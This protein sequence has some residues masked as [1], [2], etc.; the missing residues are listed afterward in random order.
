MPAIESSACY[1]DALL[2]PGGLKSLSAQ[3]IGFMNSVVPD[4]HHE[5][6]SLKYKPVNKKFVMRTQELIVNNEHQEPGPPVGPHQLAADGLPIPRRVLCDPVCI[7]LEWTTP[8]KAGCGLVNQGNTCFLNSV[9]QCLSYTPPLVHYFESGGHDETGCGVAGFCAMCVLSRHVHNVFTKNCAALKPQPVTKNLTKIAKHMR[10]GRQEDAHEFLRYFV[11]ALQKSCVIPF[12]GKLDN[13]TKETT[14]VHQVF[15]GY[16]RS[17]VKCLQCHHESNTYDPILDVSLDIKL[18]NSLTQSFEQYVK[19][20]LLDGANMYKCEQCKCMVKARKSLSIHR[21]PNVLTIQ[22]KRFD[23]SSMFGGKINK[24]VTYGCELNLR[25]YM[26]AKKGDAMMYDLYAVLVHAG[27]SVHSGHYFCFTRTSTGDCYCF[28]DS[29]VRR[30]NLTQLLS[31]QAY[32]LFYRRRVG[33]NTPVQPNSRSEKCLPQHRQQQPVASQ[34]KSEPMIGPRLPTP[35][36]PKPVDPVAESVFGPFA[37]PKQVKQRPKMAAESASKGSKHAHQSSEAKASASVGSNANVPPSGGKVQDGCTKPLFKPIKGLSTNPKAAS[38]VFSQPPRSIG[39]VTSNSNT[40]SS[41]SSSSSSSSTSYQPFNQVSPSKSDDQQSQASNISTAGLRHAKPCAIISPRQ[42]VKSPSPVFTS[43]EKDM[44]SPKKASP[45]SPVGKVA[46]SPEKQTGTSEPMTHAEKP[47]PSQQAES[48]IPGNCAESPSPRKPAESASTAKRLTSPPLSPAAVATATAVVNSTCKT[49]TEDGKAVRNQQVSPPKPGMRHTSPRR[50]DTR[51]S[52]APQ[53]LAESPS[54]TVPPSPCSAGRTLKPVL[55]SMQPELSAFARL[56]NYSSDESSC[57]SVSPANKNKKRNARLETRTSSCEKSDY[58]I[59]SSKA[60]KH[61]TAAAAASK[62]ASS[63]FRRSSAAEVDQLFDDAIG[64]G[65]ASPASMP[66]FSGDEYLLADNRVPGNGESS[67]QQEQQK[68]RS[69]NKILASYSEDTGSSASEE[70]STRQQPAMTPRNS[71][72]L[73][74]KPWHQYTSSSDKD[75]SHHRSS[76]QNVGVHEETTVAAASSTT[77]D[78]EVADDRQYELN[79]PRRLKLKKV[80]KEKKHKKDKDQKEG[81]REKRKKKRHVRSDPDE[82]SPLKHADRPAH[83]EKW[84]VKHADTALSST[85]YVSPDQSEKLVGHKGAGKEHSR[86]SAKK[87]R[88]E[89]TSCDSDDVA[90]PAVHSGKRRKRSPSVDGDSPPKRTRQDDSKS[91][92]RSYPRVYQSSSG[93]SNAGHGV[94]DRQNKHDDLSR[95]AAN[96]D[97]PHD[98]DQHSTSARKYAASDKNHKAK[99]SS[100]SKGSGSSSS[101]DY[102]DRDSRAEEH[103]SR[104]PLH[105]HSSRHAYSHGHTERSAGTRG[106]SSHAS[107]SGYTS[108][109]SEEYSHSHNHHKQ[110]VSPETG[111]AHERA[112]GHEDAEYDKSRHRHHSDVSAKESRRRDEERTRSAHERATGH[113]DAEHD[114]SRHRHHSD[115]SAKES[116]RRDEEHTRSAHERATGHEDAEHDKSRHR[117]HSDVSAKESRRRD[118]ECTRSAHERATG[119][120]DAEYDK[121]RHHHHSDVSAKESRRRDEERTP[122]KHGKAHMDREESHRGR[123]GARSRHSDS[124]Q[125][126]VSNRDDSE[127][128]ISNRGD[129]ERAS[130]KQ[131]KKSVTATRKSRVLDESWSNS[132]GDKYPAKDKSHRDHD[133]SRSDPAQERTNGYDSAEHRPSRH[134]DKSRTVLNDVQHPRAKKRDHSCASADAKEDQHR[135]QRSDSD[136]SPVRHAKRKRHPSPS[137]V[138]KHTPTLSLHSPLAKRPRDSAASAS[139]PPSHGDDHRERVRRRHRRRRSST[140]SPHTPRRRSR[141]YDHDHHRRH[142]QHQHHRRHQSHT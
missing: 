117:H 79:K 58:G 61:D 140:R 12:P 26:S 17:Q 25:P 99:H 123:D 100:S 36:K 127:R 7:N 38:N 89:Y 49:S 66:S 136:D 107:T 105:S 96:D 80:K 24:D 128:G 137:P 3:R 32:L 82:E 81:R 13:P 6:L 63:A 42:N 78:V 43:G 83:A 71:S 59:Y 86:S 133:E 40:S 8:S 132:N 1:L 46:P 4:R 51:E 64:Y 44:H 113:E 56:A 57:T 10:N 102:K 94:P 20:D 21:A 114:K 90:A 92:H 109:K 72:A 65:S 103:H 9:M 95:H 19:P 47:S 15:G 141:A 91:E 11:E 34:C 119:H 112:T 101:K 120:E 73:L 116:R 77:D 50:S 39:C 16:H 28:N 138:K 126:R 106:E 53:K 60:E 124:A 131:D 108:R 23:Y 48:P 22:L 75:Q 33:G 125:Q 115:V 45:T 139:S 67:H 18:A 111:T 52:A 62:H 84:P 14:F 118:E 76:S 37:T 87:E 104:S 130:Q 68:K 69:K 27:H 31:Q 134:Q 54:V 122:S 97:Q 74:T 5:H 2:G 142:H 30:V 110:H 98:R 88:Q 55:S 29:L 121:S 129:S 93:R 70:D 85:P 135:R 41:G 35:A